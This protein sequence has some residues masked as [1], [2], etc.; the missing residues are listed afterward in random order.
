MIDDKFMKR[1]QS[2]VNRNKSIVSLGVK[3]TVGDVREYIYEHWSNGSDNDERNITEG[4][5]TQ[6]VS[7]SSSL[8]LPSEPEESVS[9]LSVPN[10][11]QESS[12]LDKPKGGSIAYGKQEFI[13]LANEEF[14]NE[15]QEIKDEI[16]NHLLSQSIRS[17]RSLKS[18]LA[19]I[20]A[21]ELTLF[22]KAYTDHANTRKHELESLRQSLSVRSVEEESREGKFQSDLN[23]MLDSYLKEFG[24]L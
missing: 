4:L 12:A 8:A 22:Q 21:T 20:R 16:V 19:Q 15:P 1:V 6:V 23:N 18:A 2:S 7:A 14:G 24:V 10:K 11:P 17:A 3:V 9:T 13:Q 5:V